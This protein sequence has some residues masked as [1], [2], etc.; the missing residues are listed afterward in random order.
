MP[1]NLALDDKLIERAVK[2]GKHRT[3]REA[4]A[5]ALEEYVKTKRRF[6]VLD[7]M[8]KIDFDPEWDYKAARRNDANRIS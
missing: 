2:V 7:L 6:G 4:V 5:T 1:T 8:G 3:K